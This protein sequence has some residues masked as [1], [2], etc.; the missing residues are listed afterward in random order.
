M[1]F[2]HWAGISPYT[3]PYGLAETYVFGKQSLE[4][5]LCGPFWLQAQALHHN[6]APLLPKLQGEIAEFLNVGSLARLRILSSPTCVGLRYGHRPT[7]KLLF[8]AIQV[9][10][11]RSRTSWLPL[12]IEAIPHPIEGRLTTR[13]TTWSNIGQWGRN[14][15]RLSIAYA[16]RPR[17]RPA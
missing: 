17:L 8:L 6:E 13:R 15:N 4:P 10:S 7:T 2:R 14:I 1:T 5:F 3:S 9:L 12:I 16:F 11:L